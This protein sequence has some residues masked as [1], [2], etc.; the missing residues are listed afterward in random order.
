MKALEDQCVAEEGVI[1]HFRKCNE[2]LMNE[3]DQY[4]DALYTLNKEVKE[5]IEKLEEEGR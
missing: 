4:K 3:Q 1:N 2:N 5:L